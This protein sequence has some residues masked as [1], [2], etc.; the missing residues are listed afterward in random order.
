MFDL[1]KNKIVYITTTEKYREI[2]ILL[3][4]LQINGRNLLCSSC[5]CSDSMRLQSLEN[6][7]ETR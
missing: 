1:I 7:T 2:Y 6:K 4:Y 3:L 5:L